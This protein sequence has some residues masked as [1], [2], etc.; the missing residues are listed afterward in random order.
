MGMKKKVLLYILSIWLLYILK[1]CSCVPSP[2]NFKTVFPNL[3]LFLADLDIQYRAELDRDPEVDKVK[4][5][6][7]CYSTIEASSNVA[8]IYKMTNGET[9]SFWQ[10]DGSA[11]SHWIR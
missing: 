5:V 3:Y 8:D 9:A 2:H 10:S 7:Q 6:T 11:R 4:V 1:Q